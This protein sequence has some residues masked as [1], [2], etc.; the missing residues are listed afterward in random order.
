MQ[1]N[2]QKFDSRELVTVRDKIESD[3]S[4]ILASWLNGLRYG[5]EWFKLIDSKCYYSS[6]HQVLDVMLRKPTVT[7][8]I[9]CLLEDPDII[10]GFSVYEGDRLDW[11]FVKQ[12]WR[13]IGIAKQLVPDSI[14]T[15]THLTKPGKAIAKKKGL[16]FNPFAF[17]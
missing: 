9:A 17:R 3:E 11:V 2:E 6:Y 15:V 7:I 10:L 5:N 13:N 12:R 16:L 8:K 4:F 1:V 14:T